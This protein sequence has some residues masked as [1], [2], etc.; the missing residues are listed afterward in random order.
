MTILGLPALACT[1]QS[2][3]V[4][5]GGSPT[6]L[7]IPPVASAVETSAPED[8]LDEELFTHPSARAFDCGRDRTRVFVCG[9]SYRAPDHPA[10]RPYDQCSEKADM[11]SHEVVVGP[12]PHQAPFDSALTA[13][14]RTHTKGDEKACCY[15]QCVDVKAR[16]VASDLPTGYSSR[17]E[18][19]TAMQRGTRHPAPVRSDCPVAVDFGGGQDGSYAAPFHADNTDWRTKWVRE[20]TG[21]QDLN[22]CCYQNAMRYRPPVRG[23][24][25]RDGQGELV[26]AESRATASWLAGPAAL[27]VEGLSP[28]VRAELAARWERDAALEHASV[29]AFSQLSLSLLACAAPP[30]LVAEAHRAAL[31]EIRHTELCYALASRYRRAAVGPG[32]LAVPSAPARDVV[33]LAVETFVDGCVGETVAAVIAA[34]SAAGCEIGA[35]RAALE[36]IAEDEERHAELAWRI[37]R[38]AAPFPGV[39][40]A[41]ASELAALRSEPRPETQVEPDL[42]AHGWLG[43]A[44]EERARA[45]VVA[46]LVIPCAE[47]LLGA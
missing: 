6:V 14:F 27:D 43:P 34:R 20:R 1:K 29:A 2:P 8:K 16:P 26:F 44:G 42:V 46:Q 21:F 36:V 30:E 3:S 35:V 47:A 32:P 17:L 10:K 31:D 5:D 4:D 28:A 45:D 40:E 25:L 12:N 23:R 19:I 38:W 7:E 41:L 9:R 22:V 13:R 33:A 24:A 15:S 18:C 37:L 39:R 11:V